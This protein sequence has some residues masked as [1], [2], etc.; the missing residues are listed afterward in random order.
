MFMKLRRRFKF[1]LLI[2]VMLLIGAVVL[3]L[4]NKNEDKPILQK[5]EINYVNLI[6]EYEFEGIDADF[7]TFINKN[8]NGSLKELHSLLEDS[9]YDVTLWHEITGFSLNVLKDEYIGTM[10]EVIV[11]GNTVTFV[12]DVSLA[13]NYYIMQAYNARGTGLVGILSVEMIDYLNNSAVTIANSEFAFGYGQNKLPGKQF[14]FYSNP[15]NVNIYHEM[16]VDLVTLANNHV[17]D[18]GYTDFVTTLETLD[19]AEIG[20]IG[21]G[22]NLEEASKAYYYIINGYKVA[23][24]SAN[25]SEKT[26]LTPG[27]TD[28]E[29]GVFR[30]YDPQNLINAISLEKSR[31]DIVIPIL[32]WGAEGEHRIEEVIM[33][34][35]KMY[36]DAGA[37]AI[38][39]HHAHELQGIEFYDGKPIFYNIGNFIFDNYSREVGV[40][41]FTINED[42]TMDYLFLPGLQN[43][44]KTNFLEGDQK[45]LWIDK[46]NDW[47][48]NTII[49]SEGNVSQNIN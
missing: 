19:N 37:D 13:D 48:I 22:Q 16:G 21:A 36:L 7:L 28:T 5:E 11:D 8:Y 24:L 49:D 1:V 6:D 32:H 43:N 18:Y 10:S 15:D 2:I 25:R 39:G 29:A 40:V 46:M 34:T 23:F 3:L 17:Y 9:E 27:A 26:I 47:S 12:G 30:C 42:M 41:T 31:S 35:G 4:F 20:R 45:Q 33:E 44:M 14:A 38:V